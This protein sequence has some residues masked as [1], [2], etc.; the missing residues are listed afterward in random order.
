M[1]NN[2]IYA[3]VVLSILLMVGFGIA[4]VWFFIIA[5][6]KILGTKLKHKELELVFQKELLDNAV[7]VQENERDRIA[8]ELHDDIGSKL[9]IAIL[10][11]HLLKKRLEN[12]EDSKLLFHRIENSINESAKRTRTISHE[13]MPPVFQNFGFG[14]ALE[15]L[16]SSLN[17][18]GEIKIAI[19]YYQNVNIKDK[20]KLLHI[21]RILQELLS[22]T[23]K[24]GK[25]TIVDISFEKENNM[26][27]L[28]YKDNGRGFDKSQYV[29]GLGFNNI[30]TRCELLRGEMKYDS[31]IGLGFKMSIKFYNHD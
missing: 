15:E 9:N 26:I 31:A 18:A 16:Q 19:N 28:E 21:Y 22:N 1:S 29:K 14:Y 5:Q 25:A 11:I 30:Q 6:K 12:D 8:K 10:N 3:L 23:I 13:L 17:A 27:R 20:I 24:H 7:T 2:E 4:V